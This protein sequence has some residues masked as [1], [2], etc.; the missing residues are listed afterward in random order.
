[1]SVIEFPDARSRDDF[2]TF[3]LRARKVRPLGDIRL[4]TIDSLLVMTVA[5]LEGSGLMGEGTVLG[6]RVV[7]A[8]ADEPIDV[9]VSFAAVRDRL[10]RTDLSPTTFPV[11]PTTVNAPWAG[12][13]PPRAGWE[14]AGTLQP[15]EVDRIAARGIEAV[16]AGTPPGAGTHAVKGLRQRVWGELTDTEPPIPAGLA[17]AAHALGFTRSSEPVVVARQ[18]DWDWIRLS[19]PLGHCLAR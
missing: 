14:P 10:A 15:A 8:R 5:V 9:T 18:G 2:N 17:F 11:P 4:Q 12:V 16:A 7:P 1:M 19:T 13:S 3:V 6:M